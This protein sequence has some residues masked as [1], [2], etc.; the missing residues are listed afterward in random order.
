MNF[1]G[2]QLVGITIGLIL[3]LL[4]L[5]QY[6]R[7][8]LSRMSFFGWTVLWVG[9]VLT[10]FFPQYYFPIA[11]AIG[12]DTPTQFVSAFS[13]II[14]FILVFQVYAALVRIDKRLTKLAQN[15][16]LARFETTT[17]EVSTRPGDL[18]EE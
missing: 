16:A 5:Y 17:K 13:I 12:M 1:S 18:R 10:G 6:S 4:T 2:Y 8:R 11:H 7:R 15:S 3:I 14:L 9:M